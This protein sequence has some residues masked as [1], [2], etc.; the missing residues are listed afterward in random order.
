MA[1]RIYTGL[2]GNGGSSLDAPWASKSNSPPVKQERRLLSIRGVLR[3]PNQC[4][5]EINSCTECLPKLA[6]L[7][8]THFLYIFCRS[9]AYIANTDAIKQMRSRISRAA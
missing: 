4:M 5:L 9:H 3:N 7:K 6:L 2:R 8:K 1:A